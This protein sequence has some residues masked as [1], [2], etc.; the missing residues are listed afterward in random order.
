MKTSTFCKFF[1]LALLIIQSSHITGQ[2]DT[3][4][5]FVAPE[6]T[7]DHGKEP[8]VLQITTFEHDAHVI[9]S[10]PANP[11]FQP[12]ELFV[13][14]NSQIRHTFWDGNPEN[15]QYEEMLWTIE[16]GTMDA[17]E[18]HEQ[19][20][21]NDWEEWTPGTPFNKGLLIESDHPVSVCYT[22]ASPNN[23]ETFNLKGQNALGY[24]FLIPSQ[25]LYENHPNTHV[26]YVHNRH[27]RLCSRYERSGS[28][29]A[30]N[31]PAN[32]KC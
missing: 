6:T 9:I 1:L 29:G 21:P 3:D 12:I 31:H 13:P 2:T 18:G 7:R 23:P 20:F 25:D 14:G 5:W 24:E 27:V 19:A 32:P 8:G 30:Q 15:I 10:M 11:N 4:F 17:I 22:V 16:N 28:I 26:D